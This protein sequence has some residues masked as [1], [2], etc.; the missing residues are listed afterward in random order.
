[1]S[2]NEWS[3]ILLIIKIYT[4]NYVINIINVV[5][6]REIYKK[7]N[8]LNK[9]LVG[10]CR[11][12]RDSII[13]LMIEKGAT[14]WNGGLI[15]ACDGG[16]M[17]IVKLMIEKGATNLTDGLIVACAKN[18]PK[19]AEYIMTLNNH[20]YDYDYDDD[21]NTILL[22]ASM[23]GQHEI[24]KL[25]VPCDTE[26]M[27]IDGAISLACYNRHIKVVKI[28]LNAG[29]KVYDEDVI[30]VCKGDSMEL[31]QLVIRNN[32]SELTSYVLDEALYKNRHNNGSTDISIL[33][34]NIGARLD[35]NTNA[36]HKSFFINFKVYRTYC[37]CKKILPFHDIYTSL[38]MKHPPYVLLVGCRVGKK[39]CVNM[40][41][42][43]LF[44]LL[45]EY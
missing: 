19:I 10:A 36:F 17:H 42:T 24:V 23:K 32:S 15:G 31:A 28:L 9:G 13:K 14:D 8:N 43:E 21:Y 4:I 38:L 11:R 35:N 33:L 44:R 30:K 20:H 41:P 16:H 18:Y 37:R 26:V 29:A 39:C 3:D 25:F 2:I 45:F 6:R 34:I 22:N 12:N 5:T 40:L 1:M 7:I 27:D